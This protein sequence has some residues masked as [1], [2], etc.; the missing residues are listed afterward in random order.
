MSEILSIMY[1]AIDFIRL[2]CML[3]DLSYNIPPIFVTFVI[4]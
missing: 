1:E 3:P 4:I 2:K